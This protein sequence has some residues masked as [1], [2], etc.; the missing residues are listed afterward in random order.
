MVGLVQ[1]HSNIWW[2]FN[3][4]SWWHILFLSEWFK[5]IRA[6]LFAHSYIIS[7]TALIFNRNFFFFHFKIKSY[8]YIFLC[9]FR[10]ICTLY[11][12][13][14]EVYNYIVSFNIH[15]FNTIWLMKGFSWS[16]SVA[17]VMNS[18]RWFYS[19]CWGISIGFLWK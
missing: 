2:L 13:Q 9:Q 7:S 10:F 14:I 17:L 3:T 16:P 11:I 5:R 8:I 15:P 12:I 18:F 1:W 6:H 19:W 4:K